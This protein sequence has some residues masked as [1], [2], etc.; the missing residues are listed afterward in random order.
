M[1]NLIIYGLMKKEEMGPASVIFLPG[2]KMATNYKIVSKINIE[3]VSVPVRGLGATAGIL[4][5]TR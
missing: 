3:N 5:A 1:R 2:C 4:K